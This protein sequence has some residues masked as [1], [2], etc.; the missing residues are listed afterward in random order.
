MTLN[1]DSYDVN[2]Y[3]NNIIG[4][5][6]INSYRLVICFLLLGF[7]VSF[8]I[9]FMLFFEYEWMLWNLL[10]LGGRIRKGRAFEEHGCK[11][12]KVIVRFAF[13]NF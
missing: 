7:E 9:S 11:F 10:L 2:S 12:R 6:S 4:S 5:Y 8:L 3:Y 13:L 1:Y